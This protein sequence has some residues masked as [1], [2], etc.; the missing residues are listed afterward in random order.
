MAGD[1]VPMVRIPNRDYRLFG[2]A[3]AD[4]ADWGPDAQFSPRGA[5]DADPAF[6]WPA[7]RTW[8]VANDVDPDFAVIGGPAEAIELLIADPRI[9]AVAV[10]PYNPS[11][12]DRLY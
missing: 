2:G 6:I 11:D 1:D 5:P 9:D 3:L 7:D 12:P 8:C 4:W 10:A